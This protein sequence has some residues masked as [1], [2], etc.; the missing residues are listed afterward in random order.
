MGFMSWHTALDC[1]IIM[2]ILAHEAVDVVRKGWQNRV[3]AVGVDSA[4]A[5]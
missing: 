1:A 4:S 5:G 3:G 2:C